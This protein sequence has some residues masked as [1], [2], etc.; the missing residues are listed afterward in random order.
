MSNILEYK[1]YHTKVEFNADTMTLRGKVEGIN[2]YIDFECEDLN[3]IELEFHSAVDDY[4]AFCEEV[5]K[6]PEKEYKGSF[7]IRIAPELHRKLAYY[8]FKEDC[9]LNSIVEK[10][11]T[12]FVDNSHSNET[13]LVETDR[14][15]TETIKMDSGNIGNEKTV[16]S[17]GYW[18]YNAFSTVFRNGVKMK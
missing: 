5:G 10:A 12:A 18:G 13:A 4:L 7:N 14:T 16:S 1:G 6:D 11:I 15:L 17:N 2:D 9:S 3:S 8:A